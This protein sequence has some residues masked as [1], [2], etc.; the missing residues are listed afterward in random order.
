MKQFYHIEPHV[1]RVKLALDRSE[2]SWKY[3]VGQA[4]VQMCDSESLEPHQA[5][6]WYCELLI[7]PPANSW[8]V[9]V[10]VLMFPSYQTRQTLSIP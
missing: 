7:P 10:V 4:G 9:V 3:V 8:I 2:D 1:Q 6:V 5:G